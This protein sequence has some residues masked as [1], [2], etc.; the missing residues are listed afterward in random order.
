MYPKWEVYQG[1]LER[2]DDHSFRLRWDEQRLSVSVDGKEVWS[3]PTQEAMSV[4][5][6]R[7]NIQSDYSVLPVWKVFGNTS[8][9]GYRYRRLGA[10]KSN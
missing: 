9:S 2:C 6:F 8:F 10:E 5:K 4:Y 3:I 7:D 1:A